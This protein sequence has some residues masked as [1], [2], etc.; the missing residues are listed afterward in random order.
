[1]GAMTRLATDDQPVAP[2]RLG[3]EDTARLHHTLDVLERALGFAT[4][5]SDQL[6]RLEERLVGMQTLAEETAHKPGSVDDREVACA[7]IE[8]FAQ[9]CD[10]MAKAPV[11]EDVPVLEGGHFAFNVPGLEQPLAVDIP[12]LRSRGQ[13][14]LE[15]FGHVDAM[16]AR[17][18]DGGGLLGGFESDVDE[19]DDP[20]QPTPEPL[21]VGTY[22]VE[23]EYLAM[24]ASRVQVRLRSEDG[25][26]ILSEREVDLSA[27]SERPFVDM[28]VG[29]VLA[30]DRIAQTAEVEIEFSTVQTLEWRHELGERLNNEE[31]FFHETVNPRDFELYALFLEGP[32]DDVR[33]AVSA[34]DAFS[35]VAETQLE[36]T[37]AEL[38]PGED[39]DEPLSR[40]SGGSNAWSVFDANALVNAL[41]SEGR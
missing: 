4:R 39:E 31:G 29:I 12:N 25:D 14:G 24:D 27:E 28:G 20:D 35:E 32:L 17:V 37:L 11:M 7:K 30:L 18:S 3:P 13:G 38:S 40:L 41:T 23:L 22:R 5:T 33:K 19:P 8:L 34:M 36:A 26:E 16:S 10:V 15:L 1:M 21:A 9:Q 6:A 2:T